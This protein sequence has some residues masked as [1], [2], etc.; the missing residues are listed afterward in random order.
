ME[1]VGRNYL[2]RGMVDNQVHHQ[3]HASR[4]QFGLEMIQ[5]FVGAI[6]GVNG[7]VVGYIIAHICLR[8]FVH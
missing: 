4:L 7:L 1:S 2:I 3:L 6:D 5:V 8:G